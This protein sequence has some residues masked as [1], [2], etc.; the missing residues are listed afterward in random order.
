MKHTCPSEALWGEGGKHEI[1]ES[2]IHLIAGL[3]N[4]G[5]KFKNTPHNIGWRVV[6]SI[7]E[8][9]GVSLANNKKVYGLTGKA[10][11][12]GK[13]AVM[14][15]PGTFMNK[16]G[17]AVKSAL[18]YWKMDP[19]NLLV[20]QD[21]SDME[22][23]K[24]KIGYNQ[25]AGGHNGIKSIIQSLGD[26]KFARLKIGIRPANLPQGGKNHTRSEK[27]IMSRLPEKKQTDIVNLAKIIVYYWLENGTE[28]TM[29]E[30][31]KVLSPKSK[32]CPEPSTLWFGVLSPV[33]RDFCQFCQSAGDFWVELFFQI[34]N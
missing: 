14:L 16:S 5:E 24:I 32:A 18:S 19:D 31:N 10:I 15:L 6:E 11:I 13:D 25:S 3:G 22:L 23:G 21:D 33:L 9:K 28:R 27:F 17:L 8:E 2:N 20:I 26:Q 4:P 7:A 29:N 30:Y 34:G 12:S 1:P